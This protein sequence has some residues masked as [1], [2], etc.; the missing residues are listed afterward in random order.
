L[1]LFIEFFG[2]E[3]IGFLIQRV[4]IMYKLESYKIAPL[5]RDFYSDI[6]KN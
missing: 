4:G 2:I 1:Y 6:L 3:S 5:W